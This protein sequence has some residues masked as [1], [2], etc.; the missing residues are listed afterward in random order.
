MRPLLNIA[1]S[2]LQSRKIVE[3]G[4]TVED[5]AASYQ[6]YR[7]WLEKGWQ[8]SLNYMTGKRALVR[9]SLSNYYPSFRSALVF[10]FDY[11]SEREALEGVANSRES[12][13]LRMGAYALGFSG[14]DYH[15]M[16]REDLIWVGMRLRELHG[17]LDFQV[18]LDVHPVLERDLAWRAGLGWIGK[19]SML[20]HREHGSFVMLG[21]L[22]LNK[23]I[24]PDK[25]PVL[26]SDHC[27]H[28]RACVDACPTGAIEP[29]SRTLVAERC[30]ST[31]TI[32]H[33]K[34]DAPPPGDYHKKTS[35]F[36]GCDICQDVC[37]WNNNQ[38]LSDKNSQFVN[39]LEK[40][41]LDF[42]LLRPVRR[43]VGELVGMSNKGFVRFFRETV[44][45]RT[46]RIGL[47]KNLRL[48]DTDR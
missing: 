30:I 19:N 38:V 13:G 11:S 48:F 27:G 3:W 31:F 28:C 34:D 4:H 17:G 1:V 26:E 37:P 39:T 24:F 21:A 18:S 16:I 25:V 36:F 23:N 43:V 32:E 2:Q 47:L 6:N 10:L 40:R 14:K 44:F 42:F 12:N 41:L 33:F 22:L 15:R 46:G 29:A 45:A 5:R 7:D 9:E 8:G 35:Q 20:I